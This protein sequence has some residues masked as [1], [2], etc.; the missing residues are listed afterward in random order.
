MTPTESF[1]IIASAMRGASAGGIV[2]DREDP[3]AEPVLRIEDAGR[4]LRAGADAK[5]RKRRRE[6]ALHGRL[7]DKELPRDLGVREPHDDHREYLLLAW[8]QHRLRR[9]LPE[10]ARKRDLPGADGMDRRREARGG[11]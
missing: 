1:V 7:G 5:L 6:V 10:R 4:R 8:R 2:G 3:G 11:L 9:A